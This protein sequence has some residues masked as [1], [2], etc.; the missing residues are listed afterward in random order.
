MGSVLYVTHN[1][2]LEIYSEI[3][4][5]HA[6]LALANRPNS[7]NSLPCRNFASILLSL[8]NQW[9]KPYYGTAYLYLT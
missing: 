7:S 4:K 5:K 2:L 3:G 9:F 8:I 6:A 1:E